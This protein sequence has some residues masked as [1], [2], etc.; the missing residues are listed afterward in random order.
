MRKTATGD[1]L[2][3]HL[4]LAEASR[5]ATKFGDSVEITDPAEGM[6]YDQPRVAITS[7]GTVLVTYLKYPKDMST[8]A[9]VAATTKDLK[10]FQR[11]TLA[12][13]GLYRNQ[14]F[15]CRTHGGSRVLVKYSDEKIGLALRWSDDDGAS[16]PVENVTQVQPKEDSAHLSY[17]APGCYA[18]GSD[19]W[20]LYGV[21][22][23]RIPVDTETDVLKQIRLAHSP[24]GGKTID[25]GHAGQDVAA[26]ALFMFPGIVGEDSGALDISYYAGPAKEDPASTLR[27]ARSTDG[28]K[29]FADSVVAYQPIKLETARNKATWLGDYMGLSFGGGNLFLA[30]ADNGKGAAHA[31]AYRTSV[32]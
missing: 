26:G 13:D 32:P 19:V 4:Y 16:W 21:S 15:A 2:E 23:N 6:L 17:H 28:G 20:I 18:R 22:A 11:V 29:T 10:T 3:G 30:Y 12:E 24:D 31:A 5:D 8:S 14:A 7:A 1:R 9:I 27:W 25:D